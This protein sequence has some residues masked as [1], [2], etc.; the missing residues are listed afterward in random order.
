MKVYSGKI[1]NNGA[2]I[3]GII[4]Y[5]DSSPV[6]R[7]SNCMREEERVDW[8]WANFCRVRDSII[9]ELKTKELTSADKVEKEIVHTHILVIQDDDLNDALYRGL[10]GGEPLIDVIH[11]VFNDFYHSL[12]SERA[13]NYAFVARDLLGLRDELISRLKKEESG[14]DVRPRILLCEQVGLYDVLYAKERHIS[15]VVERT[16]NTLSHASILMN[17]M[18]IPCI[19]GVD[20]KKE[21]EG[22]PAIFVGSTGVL[23]ID[24]TE[25]TLQAYQKQNERNVRAAYNCEAHRFGDTSFRL[26]A[27]VNSESELS[28]AKR[29]GFDGI[30][31]VRT[32]FLIDRDSVSS[33]DAQITAYST[34]AENFLGQPICIRTFD[35]GEDKYSMAPGHW[36]D[37]GV[38][39]AH[40]GIVGALLV[41]DDLKN[42]IRAILVAA[43]VSELS[44][45]FPFVS[46]QEEARCLLSLVR[47]TQNELKRE[48]G[49]C[50]K[51]KVGFMIETVSA[52]HSIQE[53]VKSADFINIGFND[54][55]KSY[56]PMA[57]AGDFVFNENNLL[58]L[59]QLIAHI[60]EET[61]QAKKTVCLCGEKAIDILGVPFLESIQIDA[62]SISPNDVFAQEGND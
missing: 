7:E 32:E 23:I 8:E 26:L 51:V 43:R 55:T 20:I 59:K 41:P 49:F 53:L 9:E 30:G 12:K 33:C 50:R 39:A 11:R 44:I 58:P 28:E 13:A 31:L 6:R 1:I 21:W 40:K 62:V 4:A 25:E 22:L 29:I 60:V 47:T 15:A 52:A 45:L 5:S 38:T 27:T 57:N 42:Q 34:I 56:Y 36:I 24:P 18:G 19:D 61:H 54:L 3:I 14:K 2:C 37:R 10:V 17:G 35:F 46:T 16:H 48:R